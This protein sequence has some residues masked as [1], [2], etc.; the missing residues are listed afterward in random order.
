MICN[1]GTTHIHGAMHGQIIYGKKIATDGWGT[2]GGMTDPLI[3]AINTILTVTM[4]LDL[5]P[6][7]QR[8]GVKRSSHAGVLNTN[9]QY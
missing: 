5:F 6:P 8:N 1:M 2:T 3:W 4:L 7:P 9:K